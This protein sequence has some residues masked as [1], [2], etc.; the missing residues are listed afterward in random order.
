[1]NFDHFSKIGNG[2]IALTG[3]QFCKSKREAYH[4][5]NLFFVTLCIFSVLLCPILKL[6]LTKIC[7]L[8]QLFTLAK[9]IM[10]LNK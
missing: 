2:F 5:F 8:T 10:V 4:I 7:R 1:M 6:Y 3:H 9:S